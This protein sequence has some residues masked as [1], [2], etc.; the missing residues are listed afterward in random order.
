[1]KKLLSVIG[2]SPFSFM[3]G[4]LIGMG[5]AF[6]LMKTLIVDLATAREEGYRLAQKECREFIKNTK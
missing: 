6:F 1:M 5:L 4:G 3:L 2:T